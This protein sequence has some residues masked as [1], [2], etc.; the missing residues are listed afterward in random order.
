MNALETALSRLSHPDPAFSPAPI[1]WWSGEPL[2]SARLRW[3]LERFAAGGVYNLVI[4]N[5]APAGPLHGSLADDPPFLSRAWWDIFVE[6]CRDAKALGIRLWFYDQIGFSGANLQGLLI[7]TQPEYAGQMLGSQVVECTAPTVCLFP[8]GCIPLG[9][10]QL[11]DDSDVVPLVVDGMRVT[12]TMAGAHRVRLIYAVNKGFDYMNPAACA[13]LRATVHDAFL[14]EAG[15]FFGDVI[16]GSFQDELPSMPTW[17]HDFAATFQTHYGYDLTAELYALYTGDDAHS[18]QVRIDYQQW[19]AQRAE[20]A[21]FKPFF[22]WHAQHGMICGFDQ[23][24]PARMALPIGA[25]DEYADYMQTHR[26]YGAPGSDHH[27]N[28]KIHSSLA[29][30]YGRPRAWIEAFHSSGWGG[31]LEETFDWLVPWLRAGLT[32]YNPHAVYY[33]TKGGWWEWAPPSTCWRQPYWRHY[34]QFADVVMRAMGILST[35]SHLCDIAVLFPTTT[36]QAHL[37][38]SGARAAALRAEETFVAITGSMFWNNP[39][40]GVLDQ[41]GRDFDMIDN[42]SLA[43]AHIH[44]GQLCMADEAYRYLILPALTHLPPACIQAIN[45]FVASGGTVYAVACL[46]A[47][48]HAHPRVCCVESVCAL[49]AQLASLP[50]RIEGQVHVLERRVEGGRI[51]LVTPKVA[52]SRFHWNGHWNSTPYD[53][54]AARLPRVLRIA[55]PGVATIEQWHLTDGTRHHCA[56]V[57]PATWDISLEDAPIGVLFVP[58]HAPTQLPV[59]QSRRMSDTSYLLDSQWQTSIVPTV[60]NQWG[61]LAYPAGGMLLPHTMRFRDD[62]GH[63]HTQGF[64]IYAWAYGP[65]PRAS[66]PAPRFELD[67]T[68]DPLGVAGWQAVEYSLARGILHDTLHWGMLGPK[69]YVPEEFLHF[70]VVHAGDAVRVRTTV[71][72]DAAFVGAFVLAAPAAKIVWLDGV[73]Y[74]D[75][76]LGYQWF[77][78]V[79]LHPGLH[80]IEFELIP[81]QTLNLRGYWA[82]VTHPERFRRPNWIMHVDTPQ[83]ATTL[84]FHHVFAT[85]QAAETTQMMVIADVPVR[86]LL[87]GREI[88]RQG[89]Y[90]PYGST[91]RVQPYEVGALAVGRHA[92]TIEALDG[93]RGVSL[94]VDGVLW[95]ADRSMTT[96]MTGHDWTVTRGADI[97]V[98]AR[99][100]R[101]Q[102]VDLTFDTDHALYVDMDPG[103]PLIWRRQHPLPHAHWLE[104]APADGTVLICVPDAFAGQKRSQSLHW[105]I[106]VG[107]TGMR[108][109]TDAHTTVTVDGH[110]LAYHDHIL[111]IPA[112]AQHATM[113]LHATQ[114]ASGA[115]MLHAPVTYTWSCG[116]T[117]LP[118]AWHELGLADYAGAVAFETTFDWQHDMVQPVL[119]LAQVRGTVEVWLNHVLLGARIWSPY[120]F[121]L[122]NALVKGTNSIKIIVTNTLAPY[123]AGHSPTHYAPHHQ[124]LAGVLGAITIRDIRPSPSD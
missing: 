18:Q 12:S 123:L 63:T 35:G 101:R 106:P 111:P 65:A 67:A 122:T 92:V 62:A 20:Q 118:A 6:V 60:D 82:L 51:V 116:V 47:G 45:T 3:Q 27:G 10:W 30:L 44:A 59:T 5:L 98:P 83:A 11:C 71:S 107:A 86:V 1:W 43:Q 39:K 97:P 7:R 102:W 34:A 73:R 50:R 88:G 38:A 112:G 70:G 79:E 15:E 115:A 26:W 87:D 22:D 46:P 41:Q 113:Q 90:D 109:M 72:L 93:G 74:D 4:L 66:L 84:T 119:E 37:F 53:F 78:P 55:M 31:T 103:W 28:G 99:I 25:V 81:E 95:H 19:R 114:G 89:G 58:D 105:R 100:R 33:S 85:T 49:A 104:D 13:A 40:A 91:V 80:V 64:G 69:G 52:G 8:D 54:D 94:L 56:P 17:S 16:V 77:I 117:T 24:S 32:L 21:F 96:V 9:A 124:A 23:Q 57:A 121:V 42:D 29:H 48:I 110:T 76:A 2:D 120:Q 61:D 68:D 14:R 36:V 108:I 75:C